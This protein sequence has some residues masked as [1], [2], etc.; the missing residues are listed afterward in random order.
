MKNNVQ[1]Q[2]STD[3]LLTEKE[4]KL[5]KK[6]C[7]LPS[8]FITSLI[9]IFVICIP[10]I[11]I[12]AIGG[13]FLSIDNKGFFLPFIVFVILELMN[14]ILCLYSFIAP[15][16]GMTKET[17]K[18]LVSE[19]RIEQLNKNYSGQVGMAIGTT[20]AGRLLKNSSNKVSSGVGT[21]LEIAGTL[22]AVGTMTAMSLELK[23]NAKAVA[24]AYGVKV[25]K[26]S[27]VILTI[28]LVPILVSML[29]FIPSYY[30]A[31]ERISNEKEVS[32]Q[33][34]T[35][36]YNKLNDNF[37]Y[38]RADDPNGDMSGV[39]FLSS[40]YSAYAYLYD[41][42]TDLN[43]YVAF[44]IS[45]QGNITR[46][47]YSIDIN[48]NISKESQIEYFTTEFN[49]LN[50]IINKFKLDGNAELF[51]I[52]NIP[53]EFT[54]QILNLSEDTRASYFGEGSTTEYYMSY[55]ETSSG[56]DFYYS[57]ELKDIL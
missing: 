21:G 44:E 43:S 30:Q 26:V 46:V 16:S 27:S 34:I 57:V 35:N 24:K 18:N 31:F 14:F 51:E 39:D 38:V 47:S 32:V 48:P 40:R 55:N 29:S 53:E 22:E 56:T 9:N 13:A 19:K 10:F 54:A 20:A 45:L 41:L 12:I 50:S 52:Y 2:I 5:I 6:Y 4:E 28:I 33:T 37:A 42:E 8:I 23:N 3:N 11:A 49:K 17:W 1:E 15:K 7:I 25:P 36:L